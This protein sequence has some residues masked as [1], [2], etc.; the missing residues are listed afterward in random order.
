MATQAGHHSR[1]G[2]VHVAGTGEGL[3][4]R[5]S[6]RRV[7]VRRRALR[8]ADRPPAVP[9]RD[10]AGRARVGARARSGSDD[11]AAGSQSAAS[12]ICCALSGEEPEAALAGDRRSARG[13]RGRRG[14][15]AIC[16]PTAARR[17]AAA[18]LAAR[19]SGCGRRRPVGGAS[20][21]P[22]LDA[23]DAAAATAWRGSRSHCRKDV[24]SPGRPALDRHLAGRPADGLRRQR[25]GSIFD[26]CR[27]W[28]RS[29]FREPRSFQNITS[30]AFSPDGQ[31]LAF[32]AQAIRHSS[33]SPSRAARP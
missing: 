24:S 12:P 23:S 3:P 31:S 21:R 2:R 11:A 17:R 7:L 8:D 19:D 10:G 27:S 29:P 4:R 6:Q 14:R 26:R 9:G 5:S 1:H 20:A 32:F 18:A 28:T 30:P 15:A 13:D 33:G 16:C 22:V 25:A